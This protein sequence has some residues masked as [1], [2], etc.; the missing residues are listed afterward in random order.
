MLDDPVALADLH[1]LRDLWEARYGDERRGLHQNS[2]FWWAVAYRLADTG[3]LGRWPT[4]TPTVVF[5]QLRNK[6]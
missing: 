3:W 4:V 5:F 6:E 1:V 2:K